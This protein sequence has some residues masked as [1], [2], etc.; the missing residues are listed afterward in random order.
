MKTKRNVG[1][2]S[3]LLGP[4]ENRYFSNG[5]KYMEIL[6][7]DFTQNDGSLFTTI[8]VK[9][10]SG[11]LKKNGKNLSPHL[12]TT[13]FIAIAAVMTQHLL[14]REKQ[15]SNDEIEWSWISRFICKIRQCTEIDQHYIPISG[16]IESTESLA[17]FL[18][19]KIQIQ[20]GTL[21]IILFV[22]H[23]PAGSSS[24]N[25]KDVG[26]IDIY[27]KGYKLHDLSIYDVV[28]D[29]ENKTSSGNV[30][31]YEE[32]IRKNGI[33]SKYPGMILTDFILV[34]GQLAQALLYDLNGNDREK[35]N[36]MWLR[37]VDVRSE[38]P[39]K[40]KVSN[41]KVTF[42]T[43]NNVRKNNEIWQSIALT[44]SLDNMYSKAKIAQKLN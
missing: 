40:E 14:E 41:S 15:L 8:Q 33:G 25:K 19:S 7:G 27:Q 29:R 32:N 13:E 22:C 34:T 1:E 12:G 31:L 39:S 38:N 44:C 9:S 11:W 43:I 36:N 42:H 23:P 10:G 21:Q 35:S 20:I 2:I 18:Q 24:R 26:S 5:F 16:K 37:E 3:E 4:K 17:D 6:Y 28:L 30:V